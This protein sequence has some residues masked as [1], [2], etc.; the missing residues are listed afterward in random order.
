MIFLGQQP[1][2]ST[3]GQA[4][5]GDKGKNNAK[6]GGAFARCSPYD[7]YCV[8]MSERFLPV[9]SQIRT[10]R[11]H[12]S[13]LDPACPSHPEVEERAKERPT[14]NL[15]SSVER[16]WSGR[17]TPV[18]WS[19]TRGLGIQVPSEPQQ[20]RRETLLCRCQEGPVVPSQD[21]KQT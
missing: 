12:Q 1:D 8:N 15:T 3:V 7:P 6:K 5:R 20:V 16:R 14:R 2:G 9:I 10:R 17:E 4:G 11:T 18:T 21:G 19:I 13:A